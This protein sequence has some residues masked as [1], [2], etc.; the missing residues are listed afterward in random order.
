MKNKFKSITHNLTNTLALF[1]TALL[2]IVEPWT[3]GNLLAE[4]D[5][6][7]AFAK[8]EVV[9]AVL[10]S[11]GTYSDL[12]VVNQ[13]T[14]KE[15]TKITD[16]GNY[17]E[18]Q[19][20]D[21]EVAVEE[22]EGQVSA[23]VEPGYW[24]YRGYLSE[25]KLPW[26]ITL[27]YKLNG[28]AVSP[29]E[30]SG[31]S[32]EFELHLSVKPR[33][34]ADPDFYKPYICTL[35][36]SLDKSRYE[37]LEAPEATQADAGKTTMLSWFYL[38]ALQDSL[39][40]VVRCTVENFSLEAPRLVALPFTFDSSSL[41]LSDE[42]KQKLT[43]GLAADPRYQEIMGQLDTTI[44]SIR[45]AATGVAGLAQELAAL[46]EAKPDNKDL[47]DLAARAS[48]QSKQLQALNFKLN[49]A[50]AG[51]P[52]YMDQLEQDIPQLFQMMLPSYEP[53]SFVSEKNKVEQVQF[54][55]SLPEVPAFVKPEE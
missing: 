50:K 29:A 38:P 22:E 40:A 6:T 23:Q 21:P 15:P 47:A 43:E 14:T 30:L 11:Q 8:R 25:E 12:I 35:S 31:A 2:L 19:L 41:H 39:E 32:G 16:Y 5:R 4:E 24:Y 36:L 49:M 52:T 54:I 17:R 27:S 18:I 10:D 44:T 37:Q 51:I 28:E 42:G 34:D 26:E 55:L 20:L 3:C 13:F 1:L 7:T 9:Y 33:T 53:K 45:E 48:E 46:A